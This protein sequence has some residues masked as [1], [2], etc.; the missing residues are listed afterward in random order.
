MRKTPKFRKND[1]PVEAVVKQLDAALKREKS[2]QQ[3]KMTL[4]RVR[5]KLNSLPPHF[6]PN[7]N[8]ILRGG[9]GG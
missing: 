3:L 1:K 6:G 5:K 2:A 8:G 7:C 4:K 9:G